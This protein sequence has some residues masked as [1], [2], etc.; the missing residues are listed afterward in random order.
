MNESREIKSILA[1]AASLAQGKELG[2]LA[3]HR[4]FSFLCICAVFAAAAAQHG[5]PDGPQGAALAQSSV[6]GHAA[7]PFLFSAQE[8]EFPCMGGTDA[9]RNPMPWHWKAFCTYRTDMEFT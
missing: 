7:S 9:C 6:K 5:C 4:P 8:L 1:E 3:M 2:Q